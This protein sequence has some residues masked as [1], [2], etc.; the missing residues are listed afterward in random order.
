[1]KLKIDKMALLLAIYS[2]IFS[3]LHKQGIKPKDF[4]SMNFVLYLDVDTKI[5]IDC[6]KIITA[7]MGKGAKEILLSAASSMYSS[8]IFTK[9]EFQQCVDDIDVLG[10]SVD[11]EEITEQEIF[12]ATSK[13]LQE[14]NEVAKKLLDDLKDLTAE[15]EKMDNKISNQ[16]LEKPKKSIWEKL[17]ISKKEEN[18]EQL[19]PKDEKKEE[20]EEK[21]EE[22]KNKDEENKGESLLDQL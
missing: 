17:G 18:K 10:K 9:E 14:R 12:D 20:K 11:L 7:G 15:L 22:K 19:T 2:E 4:N 5:G 21:R 6:E 13:K 8:G 1:M 16:D 3:Q